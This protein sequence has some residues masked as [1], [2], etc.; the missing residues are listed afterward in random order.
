MVGGF[1]HLADGL[2]DGGEWA[3]RHMALSFVFG[4]VEFVPDVT[5]FFGFVGGLDAFGDE[6]MDDLD[7][8]AKLLGQFVK[9]AGFLKCLGESGWCVGMDHDLFHGQPFWRYLLCA[10]PVRLLDWIFHQVPV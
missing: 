4:Q 5:S 2:L 7:V 10:Y 8:D 9:T 1:D 3:A 6:G